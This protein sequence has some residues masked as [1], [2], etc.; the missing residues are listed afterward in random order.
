M[1]RCFNSLLRVVVCHVLCA[2]AI[3]SHNNITRAQVGSRSLA[4]RCN[5][6]YDQGLVKVYSSREPESPGCWSLENNV[7]GHR[8]RVSRGSPAPFSCRCVGRWVLLAG[9]LL[10]GAADPA[11]AGGHPTAAGTGLYP[12]SSGDVSQPLGFSTH[13]GEYQAQTNKARALESLQVHQLH[14]LL[15]RPPRP[16]SQPA[17]GCKLLAS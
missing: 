12:C 2:Q 14:L 1:C 3:N 9:H 13:R 7:L 4:S 6:G 8:G 11:G 16:E 5:P 17:S 10:D 15:Q